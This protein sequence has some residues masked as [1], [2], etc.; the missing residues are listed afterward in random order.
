MRLINFCVLVLFFLAACGD[1]DDVKIGE[2]SQP[3]Y[4]KDYA[5]HDNGEV[6]TFENEMGKTQVF[7]VSR[8]EVE[9]RVNGEVVGTAR[10]QD[11]KVNCHE[12]YNIAAVPTLIYTQNDGEN[13]L[14][15]EIVN[16]GE[17]Y[18]M[19][20]EI[21]TALK[22]A[23]NSFDG[24]NYGGAQGFYHITEERNILV[25]DVPRFDKLDQWEGNGKI[26]ENVFYYLTDEGGFYFSIGSGF[27]G[28]VGFDGDLWTLKE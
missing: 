18:T 19:D 4:F 6:V 22:V 24:V 17:G 13:S 25:V 7:T 26:F 10:T 14:R 16:W 8:T 21:P 3:E 23:Y 28:L 27:V 20:Q 2:L 12:Y 5:V 1:C 11:A 9:G 15:C